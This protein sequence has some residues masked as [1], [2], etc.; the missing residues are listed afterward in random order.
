MQ[1]KSKPP[2]DTAVASAT[3]DR[4]PR[5]GIILSSFKGGKDDWGS[6]T[7]PPLSQ[8]V[9]PSEE[10]TGAQLREMARRA[11]ELG[12][13]R[14]GLG[15]VVGNGEAVVLLVSRD[16]DPGLAQ[17]VIELLKEQKRGDGITVITSGDPAAAR[18]SMQMPAP[19]IW[20]QRDVT[21]R[22]PKAILECDRLI[23]IAPLRIEKGR[24]SLTLD[25]FRALAPS[26]TGSPDVTALDLAGFHVPEYAI[27][28]GTYVFRDGDRVRHNLVIAGPKATA[29]DSIGAAILGLKPQ[30]IPLLQLAEKRGYGEPNLN[31]LWTRGSTIKEAQVR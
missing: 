8:P 23:S 16:A 9:S 2:S 21:Y 31:L 27:L 7:F 26:A 4:A 28:G 19:G 17:V 18:D 30:E 10:L 6:V 12:T 15:R 25:N 5:V 11:I 14:G 20:S 29:V 22:V 3:V 13:A 1:A 24:P